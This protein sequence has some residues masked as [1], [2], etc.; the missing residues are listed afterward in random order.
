MIKNLGLYFD[1]VAKK[2]A[3]KTAIKFNN[4]EQYTYNYLNI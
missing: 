1:T 4:Y 3:D 2:Y